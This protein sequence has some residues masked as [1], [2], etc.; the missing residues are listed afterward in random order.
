MSGKK[1]G[2]FELSRRKK[3]SSP[4]LE[5]TKYKQHIKT[6]NE[7]QKSAKI[8]PHYT[9]LFHYKLVTRHRGQ[10]SHSSLSIFPSCF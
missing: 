6:T 1:S 3:K 2:F 8:K 4:L 10:S 9:K 7:H 5:T